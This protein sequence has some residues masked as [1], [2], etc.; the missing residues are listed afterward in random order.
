V[1]SWHLGSG[2]SAAAS[3]EERSFRRS[4]PRAIAFL[5]TVLS[6]AAAAACAAALWMQVVHTIRHPHPIPISRPPNV[7][8]VVWGHRVFVDAAPFRRSLH[9]GGIS[10]RAWARHHPAAAQILRRRSRH[11]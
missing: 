2:P 7:A 1:A 5:A 9:A 10:Y 4:V 8:A 6:V 11:R 3:G